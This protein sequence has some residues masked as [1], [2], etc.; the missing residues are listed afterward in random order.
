MELNKL[1]KITHRKKKRLGRGL[2]SGKGGHTVGR[3]TYGQK[4]REKIPLTFEG[5]K[6]KKSLLKRLPMRRGKEKFKSLKSDPLIINVKLLNLFQK[7][8]K[9]NLKSLIEKRV[10]D[11]KE[12]KEFG[13]KILGDGKIGV[14]LE[15]GLPCS[16][17]A[18]KKIQKAGGKVL[19]PPKTSSSK[20]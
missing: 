6:M 3:G 12:A 14:A 16:G 9:V 18:A 17:G 2:G 8:E 4:A 7:G 15:V 10:V 5:T 19:P 20:K 1:P 13:V 11:A